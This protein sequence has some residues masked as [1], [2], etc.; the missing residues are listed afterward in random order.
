MWATALATLT[1][2]VTSIDTY[3]ASPPAHVIASTA[4]VPSARSAITTAAP[5]TANSSAATRPS[6]LDAPVIRATLP[7]SRPRDA[8]PFDSDIPLL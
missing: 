7:S 8:R 5:S 4:S 6:P 2:S 3:E 1:S